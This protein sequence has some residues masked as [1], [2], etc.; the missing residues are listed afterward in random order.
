MAKTLFDKIW[1]AHRVTTLPSGE[2]LIAVDR[3]FLHE[4]TGSVALESLL[5]SGRMPIDPDRVFCTMDHIV[6]TEEGRG[7]NDAR[8]PGGDVFI[9]ATRSAAAKTGIQLIDVDS[10]DQGIVHVISPELGIAQPGLTL[11]CPDSHTC[12]QGALGAAA[13]GIGSTDAE[14]AMATGTLRLKQPPQ[15]R[16]RVDGRLADGITAK[17]LILHIIGTLGADGA[18]R[19]AVEFC[20]DAIEALDVEARLT[21]CNMAVEMAAFTAIIAP[22]D[23]TFAYLKGRRYAPEDD[24]WDRAV[25]IWRT[26]MT[27]KDASFDHEHVF[28]ARL[29]GHTL[30]W[31]TSP[32]Q[33]GRLDGTTG[34]SDYMNVESGTPL[35]GLP[36]GGAFIGSCTNAR[37]SDL[38][39]AADILRG[40]RVA[41]GVT[42]I[43]VPGSMA[44]RRQAEMEGIDRIFRAAGFEWGEAGCAFCF[45]AGGR[46]FAP[47][48]RVISSTNRNFE[49]RQGPGVRTHLASPAVVAASAIAGR[50]AAP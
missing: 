22:D 9:T 4:R 28:D 45:Y 12:S 34:H 16:I 26:L 19:C 36:I 40:Q 1:D 39:A 38:R 15:T 2:D 41:D 49:G 14:H 6:S 46:T 44:V 47:G 43:C 32:G 24:Q 27:D 10:A 25:S 30:T 48:T 18:K 8:T 33:A 42:A 3:V 7:R 23:V 37:I 31:G 17:D 21:L 13:W 50:I 35:L 20:G 11:V 5:A 29:I